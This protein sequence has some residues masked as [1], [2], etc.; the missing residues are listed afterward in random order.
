MSS[1]GRSPAVLAAG[2]G[3]EVT[4]LKRRGRPL[5]PESDPGHARFHSSRY[6]FYLMAHALGSYG[7]HMERALK[8]I[9]TD[10]P[11]WRILAI[12]GENGTTPVSRI[13]DK[14][15]YKLS[16]VTRIIQRMEAKGLVTTRR[17]PRDARVTEVTLTPMGEAEL[18]RV[19]AV[20]SRIANEAFAGF[21]REEIAT[22]IALLTRV[23]S[24]LEE[25]E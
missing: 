6:P 1:D 14:A 19:R 8:R 13:A 20:A 4:E 7:R 10:Q 22:L 18:R 23:D 9:G 15:V 16:T 2:S 21:S 12:L 5:P 25:M 3:D 17:S 24:A 11:H